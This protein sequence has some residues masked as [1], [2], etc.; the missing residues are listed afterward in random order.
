MNKDI[1]KDGLRKLTTRSVFF[2]FSKNGDIYFGSIAPFT[3]ASYTA[4]KGTTNE[5][6]IDIN[7]K[8]KKLFFELAGGYTNVLLE[9]ILNL[10]SEYSIRMYEL[11]SMYQNQGSW[12]VKLDDL[13]NLVGLTSLQY[14]NYFMFEKRILIYSQKELWEH[15]GIY[16]EWAIAQ[17]ERKKITALTFTIRTKE[18][19]E[20]AQVNEDIK[21]TMDYVATLTPR[22]IAE[23]SHVLMTQYL[24]T[25]QQKNYILSDTNVFN[26]FIR[27]HVI[28]EDMIDKAKPPKDRTK[29]LAKS[30]KLDKVKFE[31]TK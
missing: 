2:D 30:L 15:C 7:Y 17:K 3:F 19:Q 10:K 31:K 16:F 11:M 26:E 25:D 21:V 4:K 6:Q 20:K 8:C 28:I 12:T 22:E 1:L 18:K 24:L 5:V 13:R 27:V 29:Y 9:A 23:K 14:K